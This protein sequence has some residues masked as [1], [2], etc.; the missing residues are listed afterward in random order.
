MRAS[1]RAPGQC[2][3][4]RRSVCE[5]RR[6]GAKG[7]E[8]GGVKRPDQAG[9]CLVCPTFNLGEYN[10]ATRVP[11][12]GKDERSEKYSKQWIQVLRV[13]NSVR[14]SCRKISSDAY[15]AWQKKK[16]G[17][18]GPFLVVVAMS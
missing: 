12:A 11:D 1:L 18:K 3:P 17:P 7:L 8:A 9:W 4:G 6:V 13:R 5:G 15:D 16:K 14:L 2:L 10:K